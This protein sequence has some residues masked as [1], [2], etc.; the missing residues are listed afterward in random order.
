MTHITAHCLHRP[1]AQMLQLVIYFD[2]SA[3]QLKVFDGS[4]FINAGSSINGTAQRVQYTATAGQTT[5]AAT[6]DAGFVDV[7]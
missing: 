7:P 2:T 4:N 3:G 6:Y 5:F 1:P